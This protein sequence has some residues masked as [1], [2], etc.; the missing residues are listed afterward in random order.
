MRFAARGLAFLASPSEFRWMRAADGSVKSG[1][2][3]AW[4][5]GLN[6]KFKARARA[7]GFPS[8]VMDLRDVFI[9]GRWRTVASR[10][11]RSPLLFSGDWLPSDKGVGIPTIDLFLG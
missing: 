10:A 6:P 4:S 9:A 11:I 3:F 8:V 2:T 5:V 1:R 7:P